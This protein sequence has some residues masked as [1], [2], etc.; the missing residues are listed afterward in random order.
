[1]STEATG[2]AYEEEHVHT[3]YEQIASHFSSTRYKVCLMSTSFQT[4]PLTIM[5]ISYE[6]LGQSSSDSYKVLNPVPL[7]W[8]WVVATANTSR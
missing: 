5:L 8:T 1:M 6:S 7:V 4:S 2:E 3:V